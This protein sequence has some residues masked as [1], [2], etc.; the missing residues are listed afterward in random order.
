ML[1]EGIRDFTEGRLNRF[2]VL[3]EGTLLLGLSKMYLRGDAARSKDR[4]GHLGHKLPGAAGAL[5][6]ARELI[7]SKPQESGQTDGRKIG[8]LGHPYVCIGRGQSL[9]GR[10]DVWAPFQQRR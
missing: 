6:Q 8:G 3:D 4:L 10:P 5:E 2:F 1:H 7:A 9:L